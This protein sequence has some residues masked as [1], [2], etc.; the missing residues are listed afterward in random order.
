MCSVKFNHLSRFTSR[1]LKDLFMG[2]SFILI[3]WGFE[4]VWPT[5]TVRVPPNVHLE[6][7]AELGKV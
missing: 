2:E 1:Y 7:L 6:V 5:G 4:A 3:L